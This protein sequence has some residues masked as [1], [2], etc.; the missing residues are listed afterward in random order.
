[1][2]EHM[3]EAI[4]QPAAS[5]RPTL[6][7]TELAKTWLAAWPAHPDAV[8][9]ATC[10]QFMAIE[11]SLIAAYDDRDAAIEAIPKAER[12][13][14]EHAV[15]ALL[16]PIREKRAV[17]IFALH[18]LR[19]T[20]LEGVIAKAGAFAL[21]D[22][23]EMQRSAGEGDND[24]MM[25]WGVFRDLLALKVEQDAPRKQAADPDADLIELCE[26]HRIDRDAVNADEGDMDDDDPVWRAYVR[27]RD[28]ISDARPQTMVGVLAK[29]RAAKA[30]ARMPNGSESVDGMAHEW[31]W[32][33]VGDLVRLHG[34]TV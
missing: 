23:G 15:D 19:A 6:N 25:N 32:E 16:D 14:Y 17:I 21:W 33:V 1:M 2:V 7:L 5:N 30:S 12:I 28:A 10:E 13:A 31:A 27:T 9:L 20:T 24:S 8:V 22:S 11:R 26:R 29:A 4:N 18:D 34:E 3:Q